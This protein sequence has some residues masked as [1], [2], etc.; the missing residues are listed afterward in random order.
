MAYMGES[1]GSLY[2]LFYMNT[3]ALCRHIPYSSANYQ[4]LCYVPKSPPSGTGL[5]TMLQAEETM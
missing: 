2:P 1:Y 4:S 5:R 3:Q